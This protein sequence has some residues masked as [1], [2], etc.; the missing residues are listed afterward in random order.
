MQLGIVDHAPSP[1]GPRLHMASSRSCATYSATMSFV[2]ASPYYLQE[3]ECG[4]CHGTKSEWHALEPWLAAAQ[5]AAE[6]P[7]LPG[8]CTIGLSV[9]LMTVAHYDTL[10]NR[11]F[12]RLG[13]FLYR[14]DPLRGCCR[15]Y[16]IRTNYSMYIPTKQHRRAV[17]RF[18]RAIEEQPDDEMT[19][20]AKT[21][22]KK[23]KKSPPFDVW[24]LLDTTLTRFRVV[25]EPL[26]YLDEKFALYKKYQVA[27][28]NDSPED[29]KPDGFKRFLCNHP[30][31]SGPIHQCWYL[32]DELIAFLVLDV[33]PLG[34]SLIYFV[35]DPDYAHLSL[36]TVLA[37]RDILTVH[38]RKLDWYYLGYYIEDCVK[39]KYKGEYGG[40]LL[41]PQNLWYV[42]LATIKPELAGGRL[43][44]TGEDHKTNIV[45][46]IYDN[47]EVYKHAAEVELDEVAEPP[48]MSSM[49]SPL[50]KV[51]PGLVPVAKIEDWMYD[52]TL[53]D[54]TIVRLHIG[55]QD[56]TIKAPFGMLT[57]EIRGLVVEFIRIYGIE[58]FKEA[59][60]E[61]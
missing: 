55:F 8:S 59:I 2:V 4:Y 34:L 20:G 19:G 25:E 10:I 56:K 57:P 42:P 29:V 6:L 17:N 61:V 31:K 28:H 46:E 41:D 45:H 54:D 22:A 11:G 44:V 52:G 49:L 27:V 12:R 30:F 53:E 3:R 50:P 39:M 47:P 26:A 1:N 13:T 51:M 32:D 60:I 58:L 38:R 48:S 36:G 24:K 16:T 15:L 35:W 14:M 9:L 33:V 43:F 40:E 21:A 18:V 23:P 7:A 5:R 37:V